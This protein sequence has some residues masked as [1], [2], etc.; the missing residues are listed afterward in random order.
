MSTHKQPVSATAAKSSLHA[1]TARQEIDSV[2]GT[3]APSPLRALLAHARRTAYAPDDVLYHQGSPGDTVFFVTGGL[4]KL[5]AH[6]RN[7]RARIVRL[8]RAG[9]IIGLT[10]LR[11]SHHEHSAVAIT[12]LTVLRLPVADLLH[13]RSTHAQTYLRLVERWHDHLREADLWITQFCTGPIR[14]RVAR[15]LEFLAKLEFQ[16]TDNKVHLLT[17]EEMACILGV[18]SESVSRILADFKRQHILE[19]DDRDMKD[20]YATDS[21][22]LHAIAA[23][24]E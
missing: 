1:A 16:P 3:N 12:P 9:A 13:L 10:G 19:H 24:N 23:Q 14:A 11:G 4:L 6:L 21:D 15:L 2:V 7:G 22:R 18:T 8:H 5:V 17:C 20:F